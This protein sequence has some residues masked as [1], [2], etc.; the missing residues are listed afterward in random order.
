MKKII[1]FDFDGTIIKSK[2]GKKAHVEWF[3][4]LGL[5]LK[6][7]NIIKLAGKKDYF[8]EVYSLM[9]QYTGL[10]KKNKLEKTVMIKLARNLYQ[11]LFLGYVTSYKKDLEIK[12]VIKYIKKLKR[13][14]RI[15]LVTTT[16]EDIVIPILSLIKQ[17]KLFDIVFVQSLQ[18]QPS[19]AELINEFV[20]RYGKPVLQIGNSLEDIEIAKKLGIVSVL[21]CWDDFEKQAAGVADILVS[22]IKKLD[23][24]IKGL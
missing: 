17:T 21:A 19:K 6:K 4:I 15:A 16:P 8:K 12:E 3:R 20:K 7:K 14:Y 13:K 9:E 11:M 24:V 22:D 23:S 10:S 1:V 18:K 5:L 2:A